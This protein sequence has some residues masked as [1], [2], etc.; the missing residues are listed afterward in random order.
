M[1]RRAFEPGAGSGP[2]PDEPKVKSVKKVARPG[3][4][5]LLRLDPPRDCFWRCLSAGSQNIERRCHQLLTS[6]S[7]M[8]A[9]PFPP[10]PDRLSR[11]LA[12]LLTPGHTGPGL[13]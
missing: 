12:S 8:A 11:A 3:P 4:V 7:A 1:S 6:R 2:S 10:A 13:S 9:S 5:V